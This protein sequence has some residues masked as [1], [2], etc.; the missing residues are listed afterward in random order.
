MQN[1][2]RELMEIE[3]KAAVFYRAAATCFRDNPLAAE[4]LKRFAEEEDSH[5]RIMNI[6]ATSSEEARNLS[7][8]LTMNPATQYALKIT[9]DACIA[10]AEQGGLTLQELGEA[11]IALEFSEWNSLFFY[12]VNVLKD[13]SH[14]C[15]MAAI[16]LQGHIRGIQQFLDLLSLDR[17]VL[18]RIKNLPSLWAENILVIEDDPAVAGLLKSLLRTMGDVDVASDGEE[19]LEKIRNKYY[20]LIISDINMP[21]LDGVE[22]YERVQRIYPSIAK[23]YLFFSG[24]LSERHHALL[25]DNNLQF[26]EKPAM[27]KDILA[28]AS[29]VLSANSVALN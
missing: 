23:R 4:A 6:V 19:G 5:G 25:K 18:E 17:T 24:R 20:A 10:K 7:C 14:D 21:K 13:V 16:K 3:D 26:L 12:V 8:S 1:L 9:M 15:K 2:A 27:I 22:L 29:S 11:I 28:H